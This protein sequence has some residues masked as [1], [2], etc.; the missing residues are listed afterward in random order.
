M[1]EELVSKSICCCQNSLP[2]WIL[3]SSSSQILATWVSTAWHFAASKQASKE[4]KGHSFL[5]SQQSHFS[6]CHHRSGI[7][8]SLLSSIGQQK[9]EVQPPHKQNLNILTMTMSRQGCMESISEVCIIL[10][11]PLFQN[12]NLP[13]SKPISGLSLK[14]VGACIIHI[15]IF[16]CEYV[17]KSC[18]S[19]LKGRIGTR[20]SLGQKKCRLLSSSY[21]MVKDLHLTYTYSPVYFPLS[22]DYS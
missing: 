11:C 13:S 10:S 22:E 1:R 16:I 7:P 14:G 21:K 9:H 15:Y 12:Q 6:Y 4:S 2:H 19:A 17:H 20:I 3:G 5:L 8:S 18:P